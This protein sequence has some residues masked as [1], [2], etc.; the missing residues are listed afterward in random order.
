[1]MT[2]TF[3]TETAPTVA[4]AM[5]ST[6]IHCTPET[7]LR[8]V[9]RLMSAHRIHA[10]YVFDYGVEDD[11]LTQLWGL[12]TDLDVVAAWSVLDERT[13]GNS[14]ITPLV[15]ISTDEPIG[16]AAQLVA[17]S[18]SGHL[19]VLDRR[20]RRPVGVLSTL[21]IARVIGAASDPGDA[22]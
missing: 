19:A 10:V 6:V 4:D 9:A 12:V 15:T 5:S 20:T 21:D 11:E 2:Q 16:R 3:H 13:A 14:A 1:M 7:P 18:G 17:E 22:A 8:S